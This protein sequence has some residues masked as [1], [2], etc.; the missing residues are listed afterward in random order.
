[1][2]GTSSDFDADEFRRNI[3]AVMTLGAPPKAEEQATFYFA[4]TLVYNTPTDDDGI[5]FDPNATVTETQPA[6]VKVPCAIEYF[7]REE[8]PVPFGAV[9]A[10]KII[11]TLLDEDYDVVKTCVAVVVGG[12]RYFRK[13]T[14]PPVGLYS[15][16]VYQIVC[17]A[18]NET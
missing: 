7:D 9:T 4:K 8:N 3:H 14:V 1:M 15:V 18:E 13:R 10:S 5:P 12:D 11:V 2:A 16:G 17:V 6:P